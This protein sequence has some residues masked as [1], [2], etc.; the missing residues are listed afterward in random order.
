MPGKYGI[1]SLGGS[2]AEWFKAHAWKACKGESL[3]EV[4]ILSLP[5]RKKQASELARLTAFSKEVEESF[6]S[7]FRHLD[8][9]RDSFLWLACILWYWDGV[10]WA[11]YCRDDAK[12]GFA[13][14]R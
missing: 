10:K 5:P 3:S 8:C 9:K 7:R 4:R 14:I 12:L 1:I 6:S 13:S 2:V 11:L